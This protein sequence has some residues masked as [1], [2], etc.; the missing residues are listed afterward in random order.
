MDNSNSQNS[1]AEEEGKKND[2]DILSLNFEEN[3]NDIY[4]NLY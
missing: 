2:E 3:K 4:K 1:N